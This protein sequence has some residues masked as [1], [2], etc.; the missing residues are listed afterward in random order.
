MIRGCLVSCPA[1]AQ[2]M[3]SPGL[4]GAIPARGGPWASQGMGEHSRGSSRSTSLVQALSMG[5]GNPDSSF[6]R[7]SSEDIFD[8]LTVSSFPG[9]LP[10]SVI[11]QPTLSRKE[12]VCWP[13]PTLTPSSEGDSESWDQ[14]CLSSSSKYLPSQAICFPLKLPWAHSHLEETTG[15]SEKEM[16]CQ[17]HTV[18]K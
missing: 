1:G 10:H 18:R 17:G 12:A 13:F 8:L 16:S 9:S 14:P 4:A 3:A 2:G 15:D 11:P 6:S 5:L 7:G